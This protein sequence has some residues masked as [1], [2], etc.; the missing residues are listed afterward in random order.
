[1]ASIA[2][3]TASIW[4]NRVVVAGAA[5]GRRVQEIVACADLRRVSRTPLIAFPRSARLR[6]VSHDGAAASSF[7]GRQPIFDESL[8]VYGY[9]LLYR[10]GD[11]AKAVFT[12]QDS[13]SAEIALDAFLEFGF[14]TLVADRRAFINLTRTVLLSGFC[15]QLPPDRVVIEILENTVCDDDVVR[16]VEALS[17]NGYCVALDDFVADDERTKLLPHASIVKLDLEAFDE[18]ALRRQTERL[19]GYPIELV[20]ERVETRE[21]LELCRELGFRYFQGFF[22]ARPAT[23]SGRRVPVERLTAMRALALLADDET[24]LDRLAE[25]VAA[26]VKLSYQVL[27]AVNSAASAA[28]APIDSIPTAIMRLGRNQLRAWLSVMA[29]SG[30]ERKPP[31]LLSLALSR[32]RMCEALATM[33]PGASAG[34]WFMAGLLSTLDALFDAPLPEL[35]RDLPLSAAVVDAIVNRSGDLG[36][37]LNAAIAFERGDWSRVEYGS[38]TAS[39]FTTAFRTALLWTQRWQDAAVAA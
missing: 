14:D 37:A 29:L 11:A 34:T 30:L 27:R 13:A 12:D 36:S 32:A 1:M 24:P 16:E 22:F 21:Q 25:A 20:A 7:V 35:L 4:R 23:M 2:S 8:N 5:S 3:P 9:E 15:S 6:T 10:R 26:D 33:R 18:A 38:L 17:A 31:A 19:R 28:A 39:D